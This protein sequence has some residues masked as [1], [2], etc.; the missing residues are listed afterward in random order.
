MLPVVAT[1]SEISVFRNFK[2]DFLDVYAT[3]CAKNR[4]SRKLA[5]RSIVFEKTEIFSI[6]KPSVVPFFGAMQN[7]EFPYLPLYF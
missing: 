2:R 4:F 1:K 5:S 3:I 6:Y 7:E